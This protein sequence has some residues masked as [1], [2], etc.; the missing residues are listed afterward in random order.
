MT[1]SNKKYITIGKIGA[2]YGIHGWLK[3]RT[4]TEFG[5]NILNYHPWLIS[6]D[7]Q[8]W[9]SVQVEDGKTHGDGIIAKITGINTPEEARLLTGK[10]IAITRDQLPQL[11]KNEYYWSDLK[12]LIVINQRGEVLGKVIYLMETGSNDVLVIKGEKEYA[13]PYLPGDV[14]TRVD[15]DK[16]EIHVN[17]E[18]I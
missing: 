18:L 2:T 3:I 16:K 11:E 4:Y 6:R 12:G 13:I 1:D 14:I 7:H 10:F 5:P 15:L 8:Q 17:W 9:Q